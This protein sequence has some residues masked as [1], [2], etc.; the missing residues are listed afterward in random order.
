MLWLGSFNEGAIH[1]FYYCIYF[2]IYISFT[3]AMK[4]LSAYNRYVYALLIYFFTPM[5]YDC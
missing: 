4:A 3:V 5:K 2:Y 1:F